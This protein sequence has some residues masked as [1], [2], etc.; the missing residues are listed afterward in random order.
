MSVQVAILHDACT[1]I[2][3]CEM[4]IIGFN[5]YFYDNDI[6][7]MNFENYQNEFAFSIYCSSIGLMK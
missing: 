3:N 5:R 4:T 6:D 1:C 7:L 2:S